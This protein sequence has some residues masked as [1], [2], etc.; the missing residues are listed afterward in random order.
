LRVEVHSLQLKDCGGNVILIGLHSQNV[1]S[2]LAKRI[3]IKGIIQPQCN[4]ATQIHRPT[5]DKRTTEILASKMIH[6]IEPLWFLKATKTK[7][8]LVWLVTLFGAF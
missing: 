3:K 4:K 5:R 7:F 6:R 8:W 2:R 1:F